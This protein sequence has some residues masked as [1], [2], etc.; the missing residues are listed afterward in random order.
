MFVQI[1]NRRNSKSKRHFHEKKIKYLLAQA[2]QKGS[3]AIR[4][5]S[6]EIPGKSESLEEQLQQTQVDVNGFGNKIRE[7]NDHFKAANR[8]NVEFL[9]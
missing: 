4:G 2:A 8:M 9:K 6:R 1:Q 3:D 7:K 5:N